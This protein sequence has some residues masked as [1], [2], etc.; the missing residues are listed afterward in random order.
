MR[1]VQWAAGLA[2][3]AAMVFPAAAAD[4]SVEAGLF[5]RYVWRGAIYS[6]GPVFQPVVNLNAT[7]GL[8]LTTWMNADLD[9]VNRTDADDTH[10]Q[11]T[12]L[13]LTVY[14]APPVNGPWKPEIGF[15]QLTFPHPSDYSG[16]TREFYASLAYEAA[17]SPKLTVAR[18]VESSNGFYF[19]LSIEHRQIL[20]ETLSLKVTAQTGWADADYANYNYVNVPAGIAGVRADEGFA[21]AS[22]KI[23][24]T[25]AMGAG[26]SATVSGEYS[27]LLSEPIR[28]AAR[29]SYGDYEAWIGGLALNWAF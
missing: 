18:D 13:D 16:S 5:S 12:E 10:G 17:V 19:G 8:G 26:F 29:A 20:T 3:A 25:W 2:M 15:T 24:L 1:R 23:G 4:G 14:Y 28:D 21:N 7:N 22:L 11:T 27:T 9:D 6:D